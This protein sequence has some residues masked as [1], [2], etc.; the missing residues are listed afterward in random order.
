[1]G[2]NPLDADLASQ[3]LEHAQQGREVLGRYVT[4]RARRLVQD[5]V[6]A[7]G[8]GAPGRWRR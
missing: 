7:R 3:A 4:Q 1:V 5:R 8:G 2:H 6:G